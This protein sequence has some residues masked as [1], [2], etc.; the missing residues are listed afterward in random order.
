M[1]VYSEK[2]KSDRLIKAINAL[3]LIYS[4]VNDVAKIT[5]CWATIEDLF[6][7]GNPTHL[8]TDN[9]L[10]KII[11]SIHNIEL[12]DKK[13][14]VLISKLKDSSIFPIR[15][16]NERIAENIA[17]LIN[18]DFEFIKERV[19]G[20]SK[21]RGKLVHSMNNEKD[22]REYLKFTEQVLLKYLN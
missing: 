18:E 21:F 3:R 20:F 22:I 17:K 8:L 14:S 19:K 7:H 5:V 16:R 15:T 13:K 2:F 10:K 9:E 12:A 4:Q 11:G 1:D 6:G